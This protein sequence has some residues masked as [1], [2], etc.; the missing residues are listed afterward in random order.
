MA[1]S[2]G[3][4]SLFYPFFSSFFLFFLPILSNIFF[5]FFC[6]RRKV[7]LTEAFFLHVG[8]TTLIVS[9]CRIEAPINPSVHHIT[10]VLR[11]LSGARDW[12][13][14]LPRDT[15]VIVLI[16][17]NSGSSFFSIPRQGRGQEEIRRG[18]RWHA[19]SK[20]PKKNELK[21]N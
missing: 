7:S 10:I 15:R 18:S 11:G 21:K 2:V 5:S 8:K 14:M 3:D 16:F 17:V 20:R 6:A 9:R 13:C 12:A 19:L 4:L 1:K